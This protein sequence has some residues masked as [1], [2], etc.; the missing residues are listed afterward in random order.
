MLQLSLFSELTYLPDEVIELQHKW[1]N[2]I[3][4]RQAAQTKPDYYEL[5][6]ETGMIDPV[7]LQEEYHLAR[8]KEA[9]LYD[10]LC[11]YDLSYQVFSGVE[12]YLHL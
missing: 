2:A 12:K 4:E 6:A 3:L 7:F 9:E 8:R 1:T 10:R 11:S 5:D